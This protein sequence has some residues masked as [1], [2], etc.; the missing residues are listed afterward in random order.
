MGIVA[1]TSE[2]RLGYLATCQ[3]GILFTPWRPWVCALSHCTSSSILGGDE[4]HYQDYHAS[5]VRVSELRHRRSL[6]YYD[7]RP[8]VS[9]HWCFGQGQGASHY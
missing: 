1:V 9:V 8:H 6:Y 3:T 7:F 5:G 4:S 2:I